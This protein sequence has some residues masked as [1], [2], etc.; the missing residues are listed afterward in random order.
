[1]P[2]EASGWTE[3][4]GIQGPGRYTERKYEGHSMQF[5][6]NKKFQSDSLSSEKAG[7]KSWQRF[8]VKEGTEFT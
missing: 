4:A 8:N 5:M 6:I 1:M 2:Q 3:V 7:I